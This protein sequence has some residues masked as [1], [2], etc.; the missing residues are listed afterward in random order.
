M[1]NEKNP[2]PKPNVQRQGDNQSGLWKLAEQDYLLIVGTNS[3]RM[4]SEGVERKITCAVR[5]MT[6]RLKK[7]VRENSG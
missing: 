4:G 5:R 2:A 6:R 1:G 3:P 7:A